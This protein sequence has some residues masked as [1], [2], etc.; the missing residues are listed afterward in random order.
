MDGLMEKAS[1]GDGGRVSVV[2]DVKKYKF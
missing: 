1:G 2:S